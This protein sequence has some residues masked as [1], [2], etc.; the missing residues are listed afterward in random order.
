MNRDRN[1]IIRYTVSFILLGIA[2]LFIPW[3]EYLCRKRFRITVGYFK[4]CGGT[5]NRGHCG[6]HPVG[7]PYAQ[8]ADGGHPR[9]SAG[10]FRLSAPDIFP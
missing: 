7:N 8:G 10:P 4:E 2:L 3:M 1:K 5:G 6:K 9:R